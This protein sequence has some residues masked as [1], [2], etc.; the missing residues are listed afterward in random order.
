MRKKRHT[1]FLHEGKY[2]AE[3]DIELID[4][5]ESWSPYLSLV[6]AQRLNEIRVALRIG[7]LVSIVKL[8]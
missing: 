2:V 4:T 7:D 3:V 6:D 5:D 8:A 1:K